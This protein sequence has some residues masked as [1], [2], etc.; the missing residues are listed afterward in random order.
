MSRHREVLQESLALAAEGRVD[1]AITKLAAAVK[2]AGRAKDHEGLTHLAKN[3][4]LLYAQQNKLAEAAK[5]YDIALRASKSDPTLHLAIA[6]IYQQ[7][8]KRSMAKRHLK[9]CHALAIRA[10]D[11]DVLEILDV[12]GHSPPATQG[13]CFRKKSA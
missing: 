5:S 8:G 12:R 11:T 1:A 3:L 10:N 6:E 7:L 2:S 9:M 13:N 4:A